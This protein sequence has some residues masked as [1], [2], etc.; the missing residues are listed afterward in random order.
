MWTVLRS[1]VKAKTPPLSI[2]PAFALGFWFIATAQL[3]LVLADL[4]PPLDN[5]GSVRQ[6][7]LAVT[8]I[9]FLGVVR[10]YRQL[11]IRTHGAASNNK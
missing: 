3:F 6:L 1:R 11:W 4:G 10:I 2:P 9:L 7:S 5:R 8:S